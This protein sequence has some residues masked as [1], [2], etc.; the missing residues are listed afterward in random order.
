VKDG[1]LGKVSVGYMVH[2]MVLESQKDNEPDV[3]RIGD[4]EP[5]EISMV[6]IPA[7][8]SVGVGRSAPTDVSVTAGEK[9]PD[10]EANNQRSTSTPDAV[11]VGGSIDNKQEGVSIMDPKDGTPA[12]PTK[13][14][15]QLEAERVAEI[16]AISKKYVGRVPNVDKMADEA[17]QLKVSSDLFRG[18]IFQKISDG[19]PLETG[20]LGLTETEKKS[21]SLQ[22]LFHAMGN[23]QDRAAQE[24][25]AFEFECSS[26]ALKSGGPLNKN[27]GMF[28]IPYEAMVARRDLIVG[29]ATM[30]GNVVAT[31][32]LGGSFIEALRAKMVLSQMGTTYLTGLRDKLA[33]PKNTAA[34]TAY[35]PGEN[36]APTEGAPTYGQVTLSGYTVGAFVDAGRRLLIQSSVDVEGMLQ[37]DLFLGLAVAIEA[38]AINGTST[39][40]QPNGILNTASI[41]STTG[42]TNGL[43][44]TF[45]NIVALESAVATANA[46]LGALAYLTNPTQRGLLKQLVKGTSGIMIWEKNEMN[47]YPAFCTTNVPATLTKGTSTS[48]CSAIIYGNFADLIIGFWGNGIDI[49]VDPYTGSSAGT[50]RVRALCDVD[51]AVRNAVSFAAMKDA[52]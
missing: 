43:A 12:E 22:R 33:I 13:T 45:A 39:S 1:I 5:Y 50:V 27:G 26:A 35:W 9:T 47:G 2:A 46:E 6:S 25:A 7:D 17:I 48:I 10:E 36:T 42:G 41:G 24:A 34:T 18:T 14:A 23:P 15:E 37:R 52:L 51:V 30:G 8:A 19:K 28:R 40:S 44:A 20:E 32:V 49:L 11:S 3:Y 29:T 21:Y 16:T 31:Q 4:W 38:A